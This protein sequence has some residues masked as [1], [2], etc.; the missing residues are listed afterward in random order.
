[1]YDFTSIDFVY[2]KLLSYYFLSLDF[3]TETNYHLVATHKIF[4]CQLH[5]NYFPIPNI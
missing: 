1:M 4:G 2:L 5:E 3:E